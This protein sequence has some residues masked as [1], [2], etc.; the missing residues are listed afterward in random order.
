MLYVNGRRISRGVHDHEEEM[1]M[2][3]PNLYVIRLAALVIK[4][5]TAPFCQIKIDMQKQA[6]IYQLFLSFPFP[7]LGN[8]FFKAFQATIA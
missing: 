3:C 5:I 8:H 7:E 2:N 4:W 6:C 1:K